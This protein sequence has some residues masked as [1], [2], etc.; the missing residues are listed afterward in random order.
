MAFIYI[1]EYQAMLKIEGGG[2]VPQE[3]PIAQQTVANTGATTQ[4][5]ALNG[6]TQFV[7]I[8]TDTVCSIEIG[9]NPVATTASR[10]MAA[11][12]EIT[13]GARAGMKIAAILNT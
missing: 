12:S 8:A 2:L 6:G 7:R 3:P 4:S 13:V 9:A 1:T 11:N 5:A 10:R